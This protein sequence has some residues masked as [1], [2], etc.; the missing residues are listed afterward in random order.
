[1]K[2][3][4]AIG[5]LIGGFIVLAYA[6]ITLAAFVFNRG[7]IWPILFLT[8]FV[9]PPFLAWLNRRHVKEADRKAAMMGYGGTLAQV[10]YGWQMQNQQAPGHE[11]SRRAQVMSSTP[12]LVERV[13]A[14]EQATGQ[15]PPH[16]T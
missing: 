15:P 3:V 5:C 1:M 9:A 14:L 11:G 13:R 4:P 6:G 8:P 7:Y 16:W 2:R 10:L 12:S